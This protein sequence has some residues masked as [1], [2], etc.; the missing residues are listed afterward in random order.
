MWTTVRARRPGSE[1]IAINLHPEDP[2]ES[3]HTH[4]HMCVLSDALGTLL[5]SSRSCCWFWIWAT[6]SCYFTELVR[7]L[8]AIWCMAVPRSFPAG[9]APRHPHNNSWLNKSRAFSCLL[10]GSPSFW[11]SSS[12]SSGKASPE[13]YLHNNALIASCTYIHYGHLKQC[14]YESFRMST[15]P[16]F[17][18]AKLWMEL[19]NMHWRT[20]V[21]Y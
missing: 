7:G 3:T 2:R 21:L 18:C 12:V 15:P 14:F 8:V 5:T 9:P 4:S 10:L 11:L 6:V 19:S 16:S 1:P 13:W 20:K 17:R